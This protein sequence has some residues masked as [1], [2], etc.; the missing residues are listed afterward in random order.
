METQAQG[1]R[2]SIVGIGLHDIIQLICTSTTENLKIKVRSDT[3]E[4]AICISSG[5]ILHAQTL[6]KEGEDAFYE[7]LSWQNGEFN[8]VPTEP[9]MIGK[10]SIHKPW[11]QLILEA[12]RLKDEGHLKPQEQSKLTVYCEKCEKR[13]YI[14]SD[15]IP[16]GKKV[17]VRCPNCQ[18][19]IELVR[20]EDIL[21]GFEVEIER[22]KR[23]E[24]SIEELFLDG[25]EGVLLCSSD[26]QSIQQI[27]KFLNQ[28]DYN[29]KVARTGRDAFKYLQGGSFQI[30]IIDETIGK[31]EQHEYNILLYYMQKLPMNI[32]R[33]FFI[34][35]LSSS[36]KTRDKWAAFRLGVD[37]VVNKN[38]FEVI[39]ELLHY[40]LTQKK[41]FYAPFLEEL[42]ILRAS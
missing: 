24:T 25:R 35:L 27:S 41:R 40:S 6:E 39:D 3:S 37:L 11:Q 26:E 29:I 13:F 10:I 21:E 42:Q 36:M 23:E 17:R 38:S 30:I 34:C 9:E 14:P 18:N 7:I 28:E 15:R 5:Q 16:A 2:G 22:W 8:V 33:R 19:T 1:F 4:G 32:R 12:A 20:D 31:T